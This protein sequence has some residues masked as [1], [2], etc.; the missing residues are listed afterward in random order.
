MGFPRWLILVVVVSLSGILPAAMCAGL[1][2]VPATSTTDVIVAAVAAA[3]WMA[4]LTLVNWWEFTS[5][6]LR[7]F[8]CIGLAAVAAQRAWAMAGSGVRW[9]PVAV[10]GAVVAAAGIWPLAR[11]MAARRPAGNAVDLRFPLANGAF[12]IT[13]GGDGARSC[14]VNYHYGFGRHRASGVNRSMRYATDIVEIG[15]L[16]SE[17]YGF[18]PRQ[19]E[20]YRIWEK[21][22]HAPCDGRVVYT[23]NDVADNTAFGHD[24]PYGVGNHVVIR[25]DDT[26]VVLGHM[27]RGS[28]AVSRGDNVRIGQFVGRVGNSG[29]TERPHLH[30]QAVRS[31][32]GDWWH[33]EP[34]AMRF[35]GRFPVR[36]QVVRA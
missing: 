17:A 1:A 9:G 27:R 14:L 6:R 28:V 15:A 33:G 31:A 26:Y 35:R 2:F 20:A 13:D 19:T 21:E 23:V 4:L 32:D 24:R 36:N 8:W 11:A 7:W 16:G 25:T 22:L 12:L 30:M 3:C 18:L 10:G 5:I 34:L 29:W